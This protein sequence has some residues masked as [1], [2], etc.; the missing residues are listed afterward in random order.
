M[1]DQIQIEC[2]NYLDSVTVDG[3][4]EVTV[5][6][7]NGGASIGF[8]QPFSV[9]DAR[10]FWSG[11]GD[12]LRTGGRLLF[13]ARDRAGVVGTVQVVFAQMPNQPHRADIAK[14]QVHRRARRKGVGAKLLAAAE[15]SAR[16]AGRTV[17]V[18]DT[19]TGSDAYRLYERLG[20][21]R[22]GEI[23]DYALWPEGGLCPTTFFWKRL[24]G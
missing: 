20:Y 12:A 19:V 8:M 17:L 18:L 21:Q 15:A 3:L 13:V 24:G 10:A 9:A 6:C 2:L 16:K 22:V 7:V 4:A 23:P 11:I 14:M 1:T 5:D